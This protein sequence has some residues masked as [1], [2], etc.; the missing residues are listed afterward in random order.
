MSL[1]HCAGLCPGHTQQVES[2]LAPGL[3]PQGLAQQEADVEAARRSKPLTKPLGLCK[4]ASAKGMLCQKAVLGPGEGLS[5]QPGC[6]DQAGEQGAAGPCWWLTLSHYHFVSVLCLCPRNGCIPSSPSV[7]CPIG[8][9]I[10]N[11]QE[12]DTAVVL[13][14]QQLEVPGGRRGRVTRQLVRVSI[15]S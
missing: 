7:P 10:W 8:A 12:G 9:G 4:K 6:R 14:T 11:G 5:A 15:S 1:C 3:V 2:P 13:R